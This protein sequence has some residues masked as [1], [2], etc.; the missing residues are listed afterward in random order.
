MLSGE[1]SVGDHPIETVRTM[2]RIIEE[3]ESDSVVAV[4]PLRR[5]DRTQPGLLSHAARDIADGRDAKALVAFTLSGNTVRRLARL[6]PRRPLI[7]ITPVAAVRNQL[8]MSWGTRALLVPDA[9]SAEEMVRL[10][11]QAVLAVDGFVPGDEVVIEAGAP[12]HTIGLTDLL[13][14]TDRAPTS[15]PDDTPRTRGRAFPK[16]VAASQRDNRELRDSARII[17]NGVSGIPSS[18][19]QGVLTRPR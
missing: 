15:R 2:A 9:R 4:P 17:V 7:A 5:A 19:D 8:A 11:D 16:L 14:C 1:T 13:R 6:H 3:V 18:D 10:V 12:P